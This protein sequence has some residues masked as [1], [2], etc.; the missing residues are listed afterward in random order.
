MTSL[1]LESLSLPQLGTWDNPNFLE[2][3]W[4]LTVL[5]AFSHEKLVIA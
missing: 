2:P 4:K 5:R 3:L 1:I